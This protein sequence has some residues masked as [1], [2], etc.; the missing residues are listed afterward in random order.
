MLTKNLKVN[1]KLGI[2]GRP[3][4]LLVKQVRSYPDCQV[5]IKKGGKTGNPQSITSLIALGIESGDEVEIQIEGNQAQELMSGINKIL[6]DD[7]KCF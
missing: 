6:Q 4:A 2:H 7:E 3:A 1:Q 5:V